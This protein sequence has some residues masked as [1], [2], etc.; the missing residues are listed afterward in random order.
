MEIENEYE[1]S[2]EKE[3]DSLSRGR[4]R[5]FDRDLVRDRILTKVWSKFARVLHDIVMVTLLNT[6][7]FK[8][9]ILNVVL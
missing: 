4:D 3:K 2:L 6:F 1:G 7:M 9:K 5:D 8:I